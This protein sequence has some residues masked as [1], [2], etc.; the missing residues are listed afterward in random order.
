MSFFR[1]VTLSAALVASSAFA[2]FADG[3][4]EGAVKARKGLMQLYG[5]NLSILGA[6]AKGDMEYDAEIAS[7]AA[8]NLMALTQI[9]QVSIWPQGSDSESYADSR[10]LAK[11]WTTFPAIVEKSTAMREAAV[12]MNAA[13]GGGLDAL[14]GAMGGVGNGCKGCHETYRAPKK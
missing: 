2:T 8:G 13:A 14:R 11:V 5:H 10:A 1:T 3:H 9:N 4:I 12:A 6:I 7:T